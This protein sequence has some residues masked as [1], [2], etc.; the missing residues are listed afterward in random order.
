MSDPTLSV[1]D[2]TVSFGAFRALDQV[3]FD[4]HRGERIGIIGPNGCGKTTL[5][6]T[7]SGQIRNRKGTIRFAGQDVTALEPHRRTRLGIARSF[8]IP[9]PF[10]QMS[11]VENVSIPLQFVAGADAVAARR[12]ALEYLSI[13]RL[14]DKA[15][16]DC[17]GLTQVDLRKLELARSMAS[18]PR[19]L[20]VDEA[21]AGLSSTEV[22][23]ILGI[24]REL[25]QRDVTVVMVE[26][27]M[28]AINT[29]SSR[30]LCFVAGRLVADGTPAEVMA[31][32]EVRRAYLGH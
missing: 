10:H 14:A 17:H 2:V 15:D 24:L 7:I 8:Q 19:L 4:L 18:S 31:D 9:R 25:G 27:I 22:D 28:H 30:V 12:Q 23:E 26:H 6:N 20:L 16:E 32:A 29:F 5:I 3:S 21:M 11:V 13:L 1:R